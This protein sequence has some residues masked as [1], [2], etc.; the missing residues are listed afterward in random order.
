METNPFEPLKRLSTIES[1]LDWLISKSTNPTIADTVQRPLT[2]KEACIYV[3]LSESY[4]RLL[5]H[6]KEIPFHKPEGRRQLQFIREELNEWMV[7]GGAN[8]SKSEAL[9]KAYL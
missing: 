8:K 3:G 5:C 1:K 7:N 4:M 9:S 2:F 6:K